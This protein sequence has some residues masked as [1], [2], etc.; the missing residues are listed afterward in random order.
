[1][2]MTRIWLINTDKIE[3]LHTDIED[4]IIKTGA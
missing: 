1:M 3:F 2:Q 4:E